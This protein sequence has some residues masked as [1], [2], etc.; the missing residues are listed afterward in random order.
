MPTACAS[1]DQSLSS[2]SWKECAVPAEEAGDGHR[3]KVCPPSWFGGSFLGVVNSPLERWSPLTSAAPVGTLGAGGRPT[4]L[5]R[6][7]K[8]AKGLSGGSVLG[9]IRP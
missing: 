9:S 7:P 1:H 4:L 6:L 3:Q 2:L 5:Q 8:G